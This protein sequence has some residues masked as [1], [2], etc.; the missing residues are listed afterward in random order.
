MLVSTATASSGA[1]LKGLLF[2]MKG[3]MPPYAQ[4]FWHRKPDM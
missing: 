1:D 3:Q 4:P 2:S